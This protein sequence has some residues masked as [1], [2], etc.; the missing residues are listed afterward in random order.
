VTKQEL[1]EIVISAYSMYNQILLDVDRKNI[2]R[3]WWEILSDLPYGGVKQSLVDHACISPYMPKPGDL[4]RRHIDSVSQEGEPPP[5]LVAWSAVMRTVED[6]NAGVTQDTQKLHPCIV[7]VIS[8]LGSAVYG[9]R[10]TTDQIAFIKAY[11]QVVS[12]HQQQKYKIS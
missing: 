4:R 3:A 5:P 2:L 11:E 10:N 12:A 9:L 1:E 6:S 8:E 7:Q